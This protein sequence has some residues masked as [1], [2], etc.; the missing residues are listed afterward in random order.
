MSTGERVSIIEGNKPVL[1]I[2]PHGA[3]DINTAELTE[4]VCNKV[5]AYGVLNRGWKRSDDVDWL[6]SQANCNNIEHLS[7]DVVEDEFLVPIKRYVNRILKDHKDAL[8]YIIHGVGND[9]RTITGNNVLDVVLGYGRGKPPKY[10]CDIAY[11]NSFLSGLKDVGLTPYVGKSGGRFSGRAKNN[12]NQ[13]Y[14][15]HQSNDHVHSMQVELVYA[16]RSNDKIQDTASRLAD[17]ISYTFQW[18]VGKYPHK[19]DAPAC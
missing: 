16:R 15:R 12:L 8:L 6:N 2:A 11:K 3:D 14:T 7:D 19:I 9:I 17:A 1:I 4:L 5:N 18:D 13:Y 10:T